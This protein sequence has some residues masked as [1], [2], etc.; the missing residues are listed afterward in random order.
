[1]TKRLTLTVNHQAQLP[2][3]TLSFNLAPGI[4]LGEAIARVGQIERELGM[5]AGMAGSFSGTAQVF[6]ESFANQGLLVAA[7]VLV[8][9][10]VLGILYESFIHP[11]TILS[12]LPSAAIG[13]FA[14]LI[15]FG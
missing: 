4:S 3:V 1:M 15:W 6:Q 5:P 9:Y 11:I 8:I 2:A 10:V 13:A 7:A 14:T 12:G